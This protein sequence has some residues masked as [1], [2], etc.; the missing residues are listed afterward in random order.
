MVIV[1]GSLFRCYYLIWWCVSYS[2]I[3]IKLVKRKSRIVNQIIF[4]QL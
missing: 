4:W 2:W 1:I 3:I